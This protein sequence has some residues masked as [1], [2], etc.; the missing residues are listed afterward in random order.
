[1][2][3]IASS[4]SV[5]A[6]A[7]QALMSA[8]AFSYTNKLTRTHRIKSLFAFQPQEPYQ[9]Q[10]RYQQQPYPAD[11][12]QES[13]QPQE[14]YQQQPHPAETGALDRAVDCANN[15]GMC[16]VDE[17]LDLSDE[18]DAYT[19]CFV[20]DGPEACENEI[21][22]RK[23][24]A[25]ALLVQGE[26]ME[27]Q[28]QPQFGQQQQPQFGQQQQSQFGQQQQPQ[29]GQQ[30]QPQ[31]GPEGFYGED[32]QARFIEDGVYGS[33]EESMQNNFGSPVPPVSRPPAV[34]TSGSV[35]NSGGAGI[36]DFLPQD[37]AMAPDSFR[38]SQSHVATKQSHNGNF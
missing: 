29:F 11:Q 35:R 12:P 27:Q 31:F 3:R 9:Q 21:D 15:F 25:D 22:E 30:Q 8:N 5:A 24:L 23:H 26:I 14:G 36:A 7:L 32:P 4:L 18:L 16:D 17:I 6:A 38:G 37:F 10:E 13:Y 2:F 28:Q 34:G 33:Y 20:E 1:M 19:G